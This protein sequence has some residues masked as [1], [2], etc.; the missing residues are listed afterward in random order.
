MRCPVRP[1]IFVALLVLGRATP[2]RAQGPAAE[3]LFEDGRKAL[4]AGDLETACARFRASDQIDP[5][6]GTKANLAEC[7]EKRGKVATAW[8]LSQTALSKLPEGDPRAAI[9]KQRIAKL[10]ARL[11][12]IVLNLAAGAPPDTTVRDGE[13]ALGAGTFGVALPLDPG[14]HHL[15]VSAP[16]RAAKT[17]DVTLAEGATET[18]EIEP[19]PPEARPVEKHAGVTPPPPRP[20]PPAAASPGPWIVGGI[21][22]AALVVGGV[23]GIVVLLEHG[24]TPA[25]CNAT[26]RTCASSADVSAGNTASN[27]GS[28]VAP[29]TTVGLVLGAAGLAAGGIWLGV[30]RRGNKPGASLGLGPVAG[31]AAWHVGASW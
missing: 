6:P 19:G 12:R 24:A 16:G 15:L 1:V 18:V 17:V 30:Q 23:S 27:I 11:P 13:T 28:A 8:E 10:E 22:L 7:E 4:A 2:A 31:G 9:L 26:T 21:G 25:S 14:V 20:E 5:A 3:A 29:L